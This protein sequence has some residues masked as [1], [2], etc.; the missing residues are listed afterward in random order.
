M[1]TI[2]R[3]LPGPID[4]DMERSVAR[5]LDTEGVRHVALMPDAHLADQVCVGTVVAADRVFPDAVGGDIGCGMRAFGFDVDARA[6]KPK[7]ARKILERLRAAVPIRAHRADPPELPEHLR[8]PPVEG[9][10]VASKLE[11]EARWQLGTLGRGNHFL[12]LQRDDA[13]QLWAMVHTGSRGIGPAIR[14]RYR[15]LAD[16]ERGLV[17]LEGELAERYVAEMEWARAWARESRACIEAALAA[18]C[19]R[20][21]GANVEP[22]GRVDVDHNH[23][24]RESHHGEALWVHRKGAMHAPDGALGVIPGSMG[25]PSFHVE[26]RGEPRALAS[27]S[28]GAG[29]AMSRSEARRRISERKVLRQ[30]EGVFYDRAMASQLREEA[31]GAYKDISKVM[32]AQRE[33]TRVV[34]RLEPLLSYKGA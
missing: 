10:V 32:R 18:L 2:E 1:A 29:R 4:R 20:V 5:L 23:V 16:G 19:A 33:L 30:T 17:G 27:C 14:A 22:G 34:R 9:G 26:G 6:L 21:L 7:K 28:H 31:P 15:A 12:E 25:S 13:G 11:R 24:Q 8:A 3:W